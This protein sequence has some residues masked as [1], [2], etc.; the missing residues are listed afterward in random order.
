MASIR[1]HNNRKRSKRR[2]LEGRTRWLKKLTPTGRFQVDR[3]PLYRYFTGVSPYLDYARAKQI[4][5]TT[6]LA[7][8]EE[9]VLASLGGK[10]RLVEE[11][12]NKIVSF[13]EMYGVSNYRKGKTCNR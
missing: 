6:D 10:A 13:R 12:R 11:M 7:A 3:F 1:T 2:K 5:V 8:V 9:R 4:I